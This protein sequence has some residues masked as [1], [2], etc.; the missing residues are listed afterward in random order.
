MHRFEEDNLFICLKTGQDSENSALSVDYLMKLV[1][2]EQILILQEF[3]FRRKP[4]RDVEN[5]YQLSTVE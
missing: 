1:K 3:Y 2:E 4:Q 5:A